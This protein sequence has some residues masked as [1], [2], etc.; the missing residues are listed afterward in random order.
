MKKLLLV[1]LLALLTS[2][3][4]MSVLAADWIA[5][6]VSQPTNYTED[7][8]TWTPL[9]AGMV[10]K[11]RSWISTGPR[12]RVVLERAKDR[13]TFKPNTLAGVFERAGFSVHT[14]FAQQSGSIRLEIDPKKKPH[15]A[16]QTPFL[17]A[18]VKGTVFT[19]TVGKKGAKVGVERGRVEVTDALSGERTGVRAGQQASVDAN[20]ETAMSLSGTN[21]AFEPIVTTKPFTPTVPAPQAVSKVSTATGSSSSSTETETETDTAVDTSTETGSST[22]TK[23]TSGK[24]TSSGKGS[25][26]KGS[27]GKGTSGSDTNGTGATGAGASGSGASGTSG[28]GSSGKDGKGSSGKDGKG[29]SGKDGKGSSGNGGNGSSG[30]GKSSDDSGDD[31]ADSGNNGTSSDGDSSSDGKGKGKGSDSSGKSGKDSTSGDSDSGGDSGK[32]KGEGGKDNGKSGQ[33]R[34]RSSR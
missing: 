28:K 34:Q 24:G 9:K 5:T 4:P 14:D 18:V 7:R 10:V 27:S 25:S 16:V 26:G 11:D 19:V 2:G 8:K 1:P 3:T 21:T 31:S 29:S 6:K 33:D 15:L 32:G 23:G 20:P 13:V 30:K 22:G 12:G 17:A